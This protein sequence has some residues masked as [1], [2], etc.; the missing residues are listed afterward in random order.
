MKE[1]NIYWTDVEIA[2][3]MQNIRTASSIQ[4]SNTTSTNFEMEEIDE[5]LLFQ[6]WM[7]QSQLAYLKTTTQH[8]FSSPSLNHPLIK[9]SQPSQEFIALNVSE[10]EKLKCISSDL[11]HQITRI[12]KILVKP[13]IET[14][15][16]NSCSSKFNFL[17]QIFSDTS[18]ETSES[19]IDPD[20]YDHTRSVSSLKKV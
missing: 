9:L 17:Y 10:T 11:Q 13:P 14:E 12:Q 7:L 5:D 15:S 1:S 6:N 4:E 3:W 16:I 18:N 19:G 2:T 8:N 20:H